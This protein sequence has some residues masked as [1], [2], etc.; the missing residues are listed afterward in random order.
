MHVQTRGW[1]PCDA[2]VWHVCV[3]ALLGAMLLENSS[4]PKVGPMRGQPSSS[5]TSIPQMT[6]SGGR[7]RTLGIAYVQ[8][9]LNRVQ[10]LAAFLPAD[11]VRLQFSKPA[12]CPPSATTLSTWAEIHWQV[13]CAGWAH[14]AGHNLA[15]AVH[16]RVLGCRGKTGAYFL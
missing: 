12:S 13:H 15:G 9:G 10:R 4:A 11:M 3:Q 16:H 2:Q 14:H 1:L 6:C 7:M 8:R 5:A